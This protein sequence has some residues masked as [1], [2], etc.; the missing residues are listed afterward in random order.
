MA[1]LKNVWN[2]VRLDGWL[3]FPELRTTERGTSFFKGK[4]SVTNGKDG[5]KYKY[6][7]YSIK[8]FGKSADALA[9]EKEGAPISIEGQLRTDVYE[10]DG[11]KKYMIYIL[12]NSYGDEPT[13]S[14]SSPYGK[15]YQREDLIERELSDVMDDLPF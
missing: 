3:K 10:K 13:A 4:I 6:A 11:E 9:K 7:L 14:S 2:N 15:S 1:E 12:V 8:A 5:D